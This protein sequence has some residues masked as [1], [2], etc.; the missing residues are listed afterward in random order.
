MMTGAACAILRPMTGSTRAEGQHDQSTVARPLEGVS[1]SRLRKVVVT[2]GPDVGREFTLEPDAPSR[3]LLGTSEVCDLRLTDPTV[4]R[5]HAAFEP[6]GRRYRLTDLGSTNGTFIDG[7]AIVSAYVRGGELLRCGSTAMRLDVDDAAAPA[8]LSS[9][10]RFGSMMGASISMRRLY[11][12]CERL[13]KARVPIVIEG[14]TGTGKEVLAEALHEVGGA[15]GPF[16]VFDCTTVSPNLVEAELFGHER[17]A[18]TGATASRPGVF[19]E[20]DGGTLLIDEMG[21]LDLPL[22]S[23][24]LRALDRGEVRRV[25]GQKWIKVDVRV[26]AATRRDLDKAVAAGRFRD[27]LFHRLAVARIELPPLRE[28]EG[29]VLLLAR[30]FATEMSGDPDQVEAEIE[31]RFSDYNWPGNVRELRNVVTRYIALGDDWEPSRVAAGGGAGAPI[32]AREGDWIDAVV[33]SKMAYPLARRRTLEEFERR[34]I[35]R[36]LAEHGGNVSAA[37]RASGLGLRYFRMVK[38]RRQPKP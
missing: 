23:K 13:A 15:K 5:R 36:M 10:I 8:Q 22:Q 26:M 30:Q 9:A 25:G 16:V 19:E 7:V 27:D 17:G 21:D 18:F 35:E 29:D 11:P 24:L 32:D 34:Y 20:A 4:S 12:L 31:K 28:R 6:A 33:A 38:A 2:E 1:T 14:E 37:A 3:I